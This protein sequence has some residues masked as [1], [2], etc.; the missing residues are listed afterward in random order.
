MGLYMLVTHKP[1]TFVIHEQVCFAPS[2]TVVPTIGSENFF[3]SIFILLWVFSIPVEVASKNAAIMVAC[4]SNPLNV[5][6]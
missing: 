3:K 1:A 2:D 4:E 6:R 5:T